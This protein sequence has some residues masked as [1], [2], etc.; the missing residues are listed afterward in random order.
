MAGKGRGRFSHGVGP[1]RLH[2]TL[3]AGV[4][5]P[6]QKIYGGRG[7]NFERTDALAEGVCA[8]S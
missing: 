2:A 5:I 1:N 3:N 4:F 7:K 8:F 6:S